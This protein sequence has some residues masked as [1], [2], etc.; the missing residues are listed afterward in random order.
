MRYAAQAHIAAP[1]ERVWEVLVDGAAYPNWRSGVVRVEGS[2]APGAKI[3]VLSE[4]NPGR[5]F[6]VRVTRFDPA[7]EMEWTGGMPFG[8]FRGVRVFS[9]TSLAGGT[10]FS[11]VEDYAG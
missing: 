7:R 11:M 1:P 6:P 9:L 3:K 5:A 4:A 2:I 10:A 8:L